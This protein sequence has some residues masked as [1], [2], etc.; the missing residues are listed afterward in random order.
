MPGPSFTSGA[1]MITP[2]AFCAAR[3][4]SAVDTF[5]PLG[6]A[7][8]TSVKCLSFAACSAKRHSS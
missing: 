6:A 8:F 2:C 1:Q 4:S 5:S 7:I 3:L